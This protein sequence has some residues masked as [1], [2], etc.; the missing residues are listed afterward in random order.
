MSGEKNL[1]NKLKYYFQLKTFKTINFHFYAIKKILGNPF[2]G[3]Y[4]KIQ[5]QNKIVA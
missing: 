1:Q 4:Y 3:Y 5:K 2:V